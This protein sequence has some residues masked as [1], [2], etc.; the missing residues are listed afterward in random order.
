MMGPVPTDAEIIEA[1][2]SDPTRFAA[3]F[4]RHFNSIHRYLRR[5]IGKDLAD[6]LAAETFARAFAGR[7]R[8]DLAHPDARPWLFGIAG[9]LLRRHARTERRRLL[10]YARTGVDPNSVSEVED[11]AGR[12]DAQ[13]AAPRIA[14]ALATLTSGQRDV[15]LLFA[16]AD[17]SYEEVGSALGLPVGTVR[18]R[19][20]RARTRMRELLAEFGQEQDETDLDPQPPQEE[21]NR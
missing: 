8:Y 3:I 15:L 10:A 20:S 14:L 9:N 1:S 21:R 2:R 17:L 12:L 19:L 18:S 4:D 7:D 16:W 13:A 11:A 5:R 6:E